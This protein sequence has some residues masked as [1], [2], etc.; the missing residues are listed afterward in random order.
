M[1]ASWRKTS[2]DR[3]IPSTFARTEVSRRTT[4]ASGAMML[5][6]TCAL[7][8]CGADPKPGVVSTL[9]RRADTALRNRNDGGPALSVA[10][11]ELDV[12]LLQRFYVRHGFK[13]VWTT[14][15]A[16]ANSLV[17]AVLRA[18]DHGLDPELFHATL[19]R[20]RATLPPLDRD[21]L[22]SDAF[23]SFADALARGAVPLER[24]RNDQILTPEPIDVAAVLD[25][26]AASADP[27]AVIETLAPTTPT[28]RALRQALQKYRSGAASGD[29][30]A[31]NRLRT[32]VVNLE[33]QR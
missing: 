14:R 11:K 26:A 16:Q 12:A 4:L 23:L 17:E 1:F 21:L 19:L 29:K 2:F 20:R 9:A 30:A 3:G 27:G 28:Y 10:G 7:A 31:T 8:A 33:R 5:A 22:L 13:P 24:R 6:A 15:H 25:E 32:I 18:G